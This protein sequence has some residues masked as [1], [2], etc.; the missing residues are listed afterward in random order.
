MSRFLKNVA[1]FWKMSRK[2]FEPFYFEPLKSSRKVVLRPTQNI[3]FHIGNFI[4]LVTAGGRLLGGV[5]GAEP[6]QENSYPP[7]SWPLLSWLYAL[8]LECHLCWGRWNS[9]LAQTCEI[10]VKSFE[11]EVMDHEVPNMFCDPG[12]I[13]NKISD[14]YLWSWK[15]WTSY[16]S[17][18]LGSWMSYIY[19]LYST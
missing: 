6:P 8:A 5:W 15:Y 12:N 1:P 13:G 4:F 3:W 11:Y 18:V 7:N 9:D 19:I 2:I 16:S 14:T 17:S 10:N